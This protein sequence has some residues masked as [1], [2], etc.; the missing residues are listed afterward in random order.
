MFP[1]YL[2]RASPPPTEDWGEDDR[3]WTVFITSEEIGY[4]DE[5]MYARTK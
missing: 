5:Q 2:Y 1:K 3:N 4:K